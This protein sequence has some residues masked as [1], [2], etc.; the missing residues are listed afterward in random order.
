M[1]T[2]KSSLEQLEAVMRR[3]LCLIFAWTGLAGMAMAEGNPAVQVELNKLDDVESQCHMT[4]VIANKSAALQSL[5]LDLVVFDTENV[6][7]RRIITEMGPVRA[8]RTIVRT[9]PIDSQCD[10][11]GAVLVNDV[12]ACVPGEREACLDGL[13]LSSRISNVRLYK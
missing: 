11:I 8:G 7:Y 2:S 12:S 4:F 13:S 9:F 1:R 10:R 6:V 5:K 3:A